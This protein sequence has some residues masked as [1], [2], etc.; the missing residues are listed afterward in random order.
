MD[1]GDCRTAPST[2]GLLVIR[3]FYQMTKTILE[4][5]AFNL[6]MG[7]KVYRSFHI[8]ESK[9]IWRGNENK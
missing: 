8:E 3:A 4:F 6:L 2:P 7:S 1:T 9:S 5:L